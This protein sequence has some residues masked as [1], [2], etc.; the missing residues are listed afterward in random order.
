MSF[1]LDIY[2]VVFWV[3]IL[4]NFYYDI[5]L[6][7]RWVVPIYRTVWCH[8]VEGCNRNLDYHESLRS[9]VD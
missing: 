4:G 3:M 2:I 6:F 8:N 7:G 5:G 1:I 9:Y